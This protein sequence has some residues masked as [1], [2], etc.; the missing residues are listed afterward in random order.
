MYELFAVLAVALPRS[1]VAVHVFGMVV[2]RA[3]GVAARRVGGPAPRPHRNLVAAVAYGIAGSATAF[4]GPEPNGDQLAMI[5]VVA[6][7]DAGD[8]SRG[9]GLR[10]WAAVAGLALALAAGIKLSELMLRAARAGAPARAAGAAAWRRQRSP[11]AHVRRRHRAHDA[12]VRPRRRARRHPLRVVRLQL[13]VRARGPGCGPRT[14]LG[15]RRLAWLLVFPAA[16]LLLAGLV[17]GV[18]GCR[19]PRA[20]RFAC[21]PSRGCWR[22]GCSP[23]RRAAAI[24]TTSSASRRRSRC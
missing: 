11:V 17:L 18:V 15:G 22:R 16:P 8:R 3:V 23:A 2:V 6:A 4:Q 10:R 24:R 19:E 21:S 1:L 7:M 12:A 9:G 13:D 20:R 14:Q 5:A